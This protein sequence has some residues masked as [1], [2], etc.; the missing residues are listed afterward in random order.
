M[1][2]HQN[3]HGESCAVYAG[4]QVYGR[5]HIDISYVHM[6]MYK[7]TDGKPYVVAGHYFATIFKRLQK[8]HRTVL[9][10]TYIVSIINK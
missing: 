10:H 9:Y 2:Q 6:Y 8:W 7:S 3:K 5:V 1:R 4:T